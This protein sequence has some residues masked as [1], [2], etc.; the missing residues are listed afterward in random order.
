MFRSKQR[1]PKIWVDVG[2]FWMV[3]NMFFNAFSGVFPGFFNVYQCVF[4]FNGFSMFFFNWFAI[5]L[6]LLFNG[7][8]MV[9]KLFFQ[10]FPISF[11]VGFPI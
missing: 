8:S 9:L 6:Q 4:L 5:V 2:W 7:C 11:A 3:F 10:W 1:F